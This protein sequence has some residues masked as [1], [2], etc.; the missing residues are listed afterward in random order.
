LLK[1]QNLQT[2]PHLTEECKL[3]IA[4]QAIKTFNNLINYT[5]NK[6]ALVEFAQKHQNNPRISLKKEAQR[7][8][9]E[10]DN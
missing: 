8:L 7:F 3:V 4:E 9:K 6:K 10:L 5:Q 1:T 2:T